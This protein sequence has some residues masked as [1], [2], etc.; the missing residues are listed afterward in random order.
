MLVA[1]RLGVQVCSD[2]GPTQAILPLP[3]RSRVTGVC[4]GGPGMSTL[5]AFSGD[6]VWRRVVKI[7]AAGAFSAWTPVKGTAL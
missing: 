4:L 7:H 3:D 1:T 5:F 6:K 2:D